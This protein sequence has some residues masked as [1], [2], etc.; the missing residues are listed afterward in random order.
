MFFRKKAYICITTWLL[1]ALFRIFHLFSYLAS[2]RKF[3]LFLQGIFYLP[4]ERMNFPCLS[5]CNNFWIF[6]ISQSTSATAVPN[7]P[8]GLLGSN[9]STTNFLYAENPEWF[10][11]NPCFQL[12]NNLVLPSY[13]YYPDYLLATTIFYYWFHTCLH[14]AKTCRADQFRGLRCN[15]LTWFGYP[16]KIFVALPSTAG[17]GYGK[18]PDRP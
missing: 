1:S 4:T 15:S 10:S 14:T 2:N 5:E 11:V 7:I 6:V 18:Y 17:L 9:Q 16:A 13:K 8:H 3:P 12:Q